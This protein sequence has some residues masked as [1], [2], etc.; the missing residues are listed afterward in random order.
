MAKK[1]KLPANESVKLLL[2]ESL[3]ILREEYS[4]APKNETYTLI[5][6]IE[7]LKLELKKI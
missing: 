6:S 2:D 4:K 3:A 5:T 7:L 1:E